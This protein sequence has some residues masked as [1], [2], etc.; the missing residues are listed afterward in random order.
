LPSIRADNPARFYFDSARQ[1]YAPASDTH[2]SRFPQKFYTQ[3]SGTV[4]H[5]SMQH[6][7]SQTHPA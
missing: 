3:R 4:E 2:N 6:R 5:F 1:S 7:P